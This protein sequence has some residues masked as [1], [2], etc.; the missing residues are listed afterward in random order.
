MFLREIMKKDLITVEPGAS[1]KEAAGKM[2][3]SD[4]GCI[5]ITEKGVLRGILTDRD[6]ACNVVADGKDPG[7]IMVKEIMNKD[8]TFTKPET[9]IFEASRLMAQKKIRRLP[10][11]SNGRLEGLVTVS[12]LAPV[13]REEMDNFFNLEETYRH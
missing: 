3:K 5:L 2:R 1:V 9:D 6:I 4:V 13:L 10:I 7:T 11:Q 8:I 12:E